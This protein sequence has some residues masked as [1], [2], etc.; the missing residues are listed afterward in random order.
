[1]HQKKTQNNE[2]HDK[3]NVSNCVQA[4]FR[5]FLTNTIIYYINS[6]PAEE[7]THLV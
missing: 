1:M 2:V 6:K 4:F 7:M 5:T 3:F